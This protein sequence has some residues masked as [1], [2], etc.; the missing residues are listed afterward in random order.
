MENKYDVIVIGSGIGSLTSAGLLSKL[1]AKKVLVLEQHFKP[2]GFTHIFKR[3]GKFTWDTGVHYIGDMA[4]GSMPRAILDYLSGGKIQWNKMN[5]NYDTFVYPDFT[6]N[7]K[8][9]ETIFKNDLIAKFPGEKEAIDKYFEDVN[10]TVKW[11]GRYFVASSFK[12]GIIQ[13][14][15]TYKNKKLALRK[16]KEYL[17]NNFKDEKLKAVLVSQWGD[18][19]LPPSKSAFAV[20]ALITNHYFKGGYY[21]KGGS[22]VFADSIKESITQNG[23]QL[24]INHLVSSI[25]VEKDNAVGVKVTEKKGNEK[26]NKEFFADTIISG[27]GAYTTYTKLIPESVN[28]T[29]RDEVKNFPEGISHVTLY[30]GFKDDPRK[31]GFNGANLWI[32]DKYNHDEIYD[33][34]NKLAEGKI[35]AVYLAFP[36]L[37][38]TEEPKGHTAEIISFVDIE[39]FAEW[40]T[41]PWK[42]R[43]Q[44]YDVLKNNIAIALIN[45]VE[46]RFPGFKDL[47]EY[48]EL[49]TP[50]S[51]EFFTLHR[52]GNIY[53]IPAIP[54]RFKAK[55]IGPRTPVKNLFLTGADAASHGLVGSLMGGVLSAGMVMGIPSGLF[56]IFSTAMKYSNGLKE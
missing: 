29:Y 13:Y 17:D 34:R 37:K 23:G 10:K 45:F 36:S 42:N 46:D 48:S 39:P 35:S 11:Y 14:L 1:S 53:G 28:I 21:P 5:D 40:R 18:Y 19:G 25:I 3:E 9:G 38:D 27:A 47:V 31:I 32:Y 24:L 56:K 16:T 15:L 26:I 43:G 22:K 30:I 41:E 20:H 2:G 4:K 51:T 44:E 6:F 12:K 54:E 33:E 52:K 8:E 49:S 7:V 50:L 55:W